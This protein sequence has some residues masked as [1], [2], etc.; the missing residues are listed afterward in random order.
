MDPACREVR[1]SLSDLPIDRE[2]IRLH[3]RRCPGCR[4]FAGEEEA[5]RRGLS[6]LT[7][8][9]LDDLSR[10]RIRAALAGDFDRMASEN[11]APRGRARW[12]WLV[13]AAALLLLILLPRPREAPA[14]PPPKLRPYLVAGSAVSELARTERLEAVEGAVVMAEVEGQ[15]VVTLIGP[16]RALVTAPGRILLERGLL[17]AWIRHREKGPFEV[18]HE[19]V[20]VRVVGTRFAVDARGPGRPVVSVAEGAVEVL[21][22]DAVA[23]LR[24]GQV[25][26]D[27]KLEAAL[28]VD[29]LRPPSGPE[30]SLVI[31][32]TPRATVFID[33]VVVGPTPLTA[34]LAAGRHRIEVRADLH[35]PHE[36]TLLVPVDG[37]ARRTYA[38]EPIRIE[39]PAPPRPKSRAPRRAAPPRVTAETIYRR[40]ESAL[41]DGRADEAE[42]HLQELL[43]RFKEDPLAE[44]ARYELARIAREQGRLEEAHRW[45]VRL[46][47]RR[48]D[49]ALAEAGQRLLCQIDVQTG[50][51]DEANSCWRS[52][53]RRFPRSPHD[54]EALANLIALAHVWHDCPRVMALARELERLHPDSPLRPDV[55]ARV[56]M[57]R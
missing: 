25:W 8:P 52:F 21:H 45:L 41:A 54:A 37:V 23:R 50:R 13:A 35:E 3:Q 57:C 39:P 17:L 10:A 36:A 27:G 1:E 20:T 14:P 49:P 33:G 29:R 32:G 15:G 40:A 16:G 19:G 12:P 53:R 18:H 26:P 55:E 11:A 5:I 28:F 22:R 6:F 24:P 30:G 48:E 44:S 34:R 47:E 38:L 56:R 43:E 7:E 31:D 46:L 9:G 42:R 51:H 4:A 2:R